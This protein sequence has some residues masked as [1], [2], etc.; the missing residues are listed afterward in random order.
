MFEFRFEI[1]TEIRSEIS[2]LTGV[3]DKIDE[4]IK[5]ADAANG[6]ALLALLA[7]VAAIALNLLL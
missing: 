3:A 4:A 2:D 1:R 6:L 7:G 5:K